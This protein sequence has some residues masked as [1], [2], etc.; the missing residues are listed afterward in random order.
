MSLYSKMY[1]YMYMNL[2]YMHTLEI[3]YSG[4]S[5]RPNNITP[6]HKHFIHVDTPVF[7]YFHYIHWE[8]P[9]TVLLPAIKQ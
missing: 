6:K 2:L 7:Q 4:T 3:I 8:I 5:T 1:T 9:P